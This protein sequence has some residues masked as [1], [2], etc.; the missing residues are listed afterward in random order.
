M[1]NRNV[2]VP[3]TLRCHPQEIYCEPQ[4][5]HR[6]TYELHVALSLLGN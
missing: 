4:S 2:L 3:G 5:V 6:D 1:E